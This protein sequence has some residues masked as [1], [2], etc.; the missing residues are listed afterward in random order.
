MLARAGFIDSNN[1]YRI[2]TLR[3]PSLLR[4]RSERARA[5]RACCDAS[6]GNHQPYPD[7]YTNN[8]T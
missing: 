5:A 3:P 2:I 7:T 8:A 4:L 6:R 1:E